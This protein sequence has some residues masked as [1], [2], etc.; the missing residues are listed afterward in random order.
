MTL[1]NM[2]IMF[3]AQGKLDEADQM[4]RRALAIFV[5]TLDPSHPHIATCAEN[6]AGLLRDMGRDEEADALDVQYCRLDD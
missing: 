4:Y 1:N 2:A 3:T 6:Y 5:R